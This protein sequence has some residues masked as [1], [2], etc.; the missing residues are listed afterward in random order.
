MT[1]APKCG[2]RLREVA[3]EME[4]PAKADDL[5]AAERRAL[6]DRACKKT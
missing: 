3:F 2:E 5:D 1:D 4:K 6:L